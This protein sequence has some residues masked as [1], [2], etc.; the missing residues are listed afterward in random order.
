MIVLLLLAFFVLLF[1]KSMSFRYLILHPFKTLRHMLA[2][3]F[4]YFKHKKKNNAPYGDVCSYVAHSAVSFGCGKTLSAVNYVVSLYNRY[5]NKKVWDMERKKFVTQKIHILSNVMLTSV[6]YEKLVSLKQF[7]QAVNTAYSDDLANNTCTVTYLLV[8]EAGAQFNSRQFKS[9]FDGLFIKTLL[10]SRHFKASVILTS[11][12]Q[13]MIDA[14]MRQITNVVIACK[15]V[16]RFQYLYYYDG[17]ELETAQNPATVEPFRKRVWLISDR[18]FNLYNTFELVD[19]LQKSCESGDMLS[20]EQILQLQCNSSA[21][22]DAVL[23]NS[24]AYRR[25]RNRLKH[26]IL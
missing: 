9:N 1:V 26:G 10:T 14:L 8:D 20:E 2:D 3:I 18:N 16:W 25:N 4:L 21:N 6:P 12:R 11:Q 22:P 13:N 24:K 23:K 7:V 5:N 17:Y 15:K 19:D